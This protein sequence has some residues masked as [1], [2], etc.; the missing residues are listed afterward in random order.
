MIGYDQSST[1]PGNYETRHQATGY[2]QT[3]GY[4]A[5]AGYATDSHGH[6]IN[7]GYTTDSHGHKNFHGAYFNG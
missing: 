5:N 2:E 6:N 4:N 3:G 1:P 7:A